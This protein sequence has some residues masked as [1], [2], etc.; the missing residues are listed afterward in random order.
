MIYSQSKLTHQTEGDLH[1]TNIKESSA[2]NI[3]PRV[4]WLDFARA[5]AIISITFNH[6]LSRSF[7][8]RSE[9]L[10]EFLLMPT[11]ASFLKALLYVF[12]RVGVPLFLMIT[13]A[14]LIPRDYENKET[15]KRFIRHNWWG[16]LRTTLIWLVIMFCFLQIFDDSM[17]KAHGVFKTLIYLVSTTLFFNQVTLPNMWYMPM[18]LCIYLMIPVIAIAIRKLGD[19]YILALSAILLIGGVI[20]PNLNEILYACG[21]SSFISWEVNYTNIFS[22]Y[23]LFILAGYW[24][25]ARKL[26]NVKCCWLWI[27]LAVSIFITTFFQLWIYSTPSDYFLNVADFGII[28]I[29]VPLFEIIRRKANPSSVLSKPI[30]GLA[31]IAFG[32]YFLHIC[33]M[34]GMNEW[35]NKTAPDFYHF[36]RFLVLETVSFSLS[37]LIILITS[38]VKLFRKYAYLI[39]D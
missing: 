17:L 22:I 29:V 39:K 8:T 1:M 33:I 37:A 32:I 6:A 12:S 7:H 13:G 27:V 24:I 9:T 34:Y 11:A 4:Y 30:T 10:E 5:I 2:R 20:V 15:T 18:I 23:F 3:A 26:Q 31:K 36:P 38:K 19:K 25:S 16:L 28:M 14:L 21:L 35:F